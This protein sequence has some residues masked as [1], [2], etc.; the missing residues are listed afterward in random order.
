MGLVYETKRRAREAI[1]PFVCF[2]LVIYFG[3]HVIHGDRGLLA[4]LHLTKKIAT[5][6][7]SHG[8]VARERDKLENAARRLRADNLDLDLL[9]ERSRIVLGHIRRDEAIILA[10]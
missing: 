3:Y 1:A 8:Q 5:L 9:E 10:N 4:Y 6:Q 2:A 7:A